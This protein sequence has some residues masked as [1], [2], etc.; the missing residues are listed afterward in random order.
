M[1]Y[2]CLYDKFMYMK[3]IS[4]IESN[5]G[6]IVVAEHV[7]TTHAHL[8]VKNPTAIDFAEQQGGQRS[9][10]LVPIFFQE[11]TEDPSADVT[12]RVPLQTVSMGDAV[13]KEQVEKLYLFALGRIT[14][15]APQQT[16]DGKVVPLFDEE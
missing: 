11:L 9:L 13:L 7:E 1:I 10:I 15:E 5:S 14:P 4:Y 6:R 8:V 12:W 16:N 2:L 3:L